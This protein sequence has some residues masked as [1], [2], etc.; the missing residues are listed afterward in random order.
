MAAPNNLFPFSFQRVQTQGGAQASD[1]PPNAQAIFTGA[2]GAQPIFADAH[3][4]QSMHTR[5]PTNDLERTELTLLPM[6]AQQR[7]TKKEINQV[8]NQFDSMFACRGSRGMKIT[9]DDWPRIERPHGDYPLLNSLLPQSSDLLRKIKAH[10]ANPK[11][12]IDTLNRIATMLGNHGETYGNP[13]ILGTVDNRR[14]IQDAVFALKTLF[15]ATAVSLDEQLSE[16]LNS[17]KPSE[18]S[19]EDY[20]NYLAGLALD[21]P[22]VAKMISHFP[23]TALGAPSGLAQHT[24]LF[25]DPEINNMRLIGTTIL[26]L[27]IGKIM[28][29][30]A[31]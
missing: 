30:P 15:I 7:D 5:F 9:F 13:N 10:Y 4:A 14:T 31:V 27:H 20:S 23:T 26:N 17:S 29:K 16:L 24:R 12:S 22:N 3:G 8:L 25:S 11:D 18:V 21:L 28:S 6:S 2:R 1:P 19:S